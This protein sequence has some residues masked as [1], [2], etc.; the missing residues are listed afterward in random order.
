MTM[1]IYEIKNLKN[2]KVYI[3]QSRNIEKRLLSH[4]KSLKNGSH[5]NM[6]LQNSFNLWGKEYFSFGLIEE[7]ESLGLLNEAENKWIKNYH[8]FAGIN[9]YNIKYPTQV[10]RLSFNVPNV[11]C[12]NCGKMFYSKIKTAKFCNPECSKYYWNKN[13]PKTKA[14]EGNYTRQ[15]KLS[16]C[17]KTFLTNR[18]KQCFCCKEHQQIYWEQVQNDKFY[19]IKRLEEIEK[20]IGIK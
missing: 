17:N 1:G 9:G 4:K 6:H 20:K 11:K 2:K 12:K 15:C 5:F 16:S 14:R 3:G 10:F 18:K 13:S 7:V 8:S 19:L